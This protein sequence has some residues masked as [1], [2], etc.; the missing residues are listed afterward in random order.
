M[1]RKKKKDEQVSILIVFGIICLSIVMAIMGILFAGEFTVL[2]IFT[3]DQ[4]VLLMI[5]FILFG[6]IFIISAFIIQEKG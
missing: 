4:S 6:L 3:I 5:P 2:R 1:A